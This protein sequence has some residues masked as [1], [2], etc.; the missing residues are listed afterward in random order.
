VIGLTR[1]NIGMMMITDD[2]GVGGDYVNSIGEDGIHLET[3]MLFSFISHELLVFVHA[4][5]Q[6]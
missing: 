1:P 3:F 5:K 4:V 6:S 2:C